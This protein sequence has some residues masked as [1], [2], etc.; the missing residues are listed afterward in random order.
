MAGGKET[1]RQKMIGMMYLVLTALLALNVSKEILDAFIAIDKGLHKTN[2][3]LDA[4]A[5]S[6][7]D[8]LA[9]AVEKDPAKAQKFHEKGKEVSAMMDQMDVYIEQFKAHVMAASM[10]GNKDGK[11]WE[12][13]MENQTTAISLEKEKDGKPIITKPDENQN[14]TTL[15]VGK[16][17]RKPVT[18][19]WSANELKVKLEQMRDNL[20]G[21]TL[22]TATGATWSVSDALKA[23][24]DEAFTHG[25]ETEGKDK[26]EVTWETKHFY[27][28]P[29]AALITYLSKIQ[30][31]VK[32]AKGD[33]LAELQAGINA[34]DIKFTDVTVAVVPSTSYVLQGEEFTAEIYLAAFNRTSTSNVYIGGQFTEMPSD[35]VK[36][37]PKNA[38]Q[39][40]TTEG[41][42]KARF[43]V[44]TGG[45]S[46]GD[47]GYR[48]MIEYT[49][50]DGSLDQ[51]P[52]NIPPFTVAQPACVVSPTQM[53]VFYRGL[54]NPVEISVPGVDVN[55]IKPSISSGTLSPG[56]KKG[57]YIV[58]PSNSSTDAVIS[59][60]ANVNGKDVQVGEKKFRVKPIPT[61]I[62]RFQGKTPM[63]NS[64]AKSSA[65]AGAGIEAKMENFDFEVTASVKSFVMVFTKDGQVIDKAASGNKLTDDQKQMISRM[66]PGERLYVEK[67]VAKMPDGQDRNLPNLSLRIT[68]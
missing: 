10:K 37:D 17:P 21:I 19:P 67:I 30:T 32:K 68:N 62:P 27:H 11:G 42:G 20:K 26:K 22:Q 58:K 28:V 25:M 41:D 31:D 40:L 15:L 34:K 47:H 46:L 13:Y 50:P 8:A 48:G 38:A 43:K 2:A 12:G 45:M 24:L 57:E 52:F 18:T 1:P 6:S 4:R 65:I 60:V 35:T 61:P 59:V 55:K 14:N 63:D 39:T 64:I 23:N 51:I 66:K 33:V 16:D 56:A 44:S 9:S 5:Q 54:D 36:F 29:L 3:T 53:N 7:L 49:K